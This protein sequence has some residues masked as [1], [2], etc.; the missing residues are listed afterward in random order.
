M[1]GVV[2]VAAIVV[3]LAVTVLS[4]TVNAQPNWGGLHSAVNQGPT[5]PTPSPT[6]PPSPTPT[7]QP[8][9]I[10]VVRHGD[11]LYSIAVRFGVSVCEL[12]RVNCIRNLTLIITGQRLVIPIGWGYQGD[13]LPRPVPPP[14][15]GW[16]GY[17][18]GNL[19]GSPVGWGGWGNGGCPQC[20][21]G[22]IAIPLDK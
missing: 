21:R 22:P 20:R 9:N 2:V 4:G 16:P 10:Y 5:I 19:W 13:Y 15:I 14:F 6:P 18:G 7:L 1:K 3:V 12:A 8:G 17:Y 11:T